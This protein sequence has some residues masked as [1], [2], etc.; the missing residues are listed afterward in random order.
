MYTWLEALQC[1][2]FSFCIFKSA[3]KYSTI[4]KKNIDQSRCITSIYIIRK[5]NSILNK[6]CQSNVT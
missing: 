6:S 1:N 5:S 4:F 2:L 3:K